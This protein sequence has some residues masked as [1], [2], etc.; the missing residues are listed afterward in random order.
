MEDGDCM[1]LGLDVGRSEAAIAD[2]TR[3]VIKDI[4]PTFISA[5]SFL[6]V[7]AFTIKRNEEA[8]GELGKFSSR[9]WKRKYNRYI[10]FESI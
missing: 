8:H 9:S 10:A 3:L 4:I 6:Q 2:P 1:C 7:A 5:E